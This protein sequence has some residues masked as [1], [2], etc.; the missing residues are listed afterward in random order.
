MLFS[1]GKVERETYE[2]SKKQTLDYNLQHHGN[3]VSCRKLFIGFK[4]FCLLGTVHSIHEKAHPE[5]ISNFINIS[6]K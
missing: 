5:L 3:S 2:N 4:G 6:D 1:H